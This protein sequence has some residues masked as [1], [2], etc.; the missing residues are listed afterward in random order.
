VVLKDIREEGNDNN[1]IIVL[2]TPSLTSDQNATIKRVNFSSLVVNDIKAF[3]SPIERRFDVSARRPSS[4]P[5]LELTIQLLDKRL[6]NLQTISSAPLTITGKATVDIEKKFVGLIPQSWM[7]EIDIHAQPMLEIPRPELRAKL[8]HLIGSITVTKIPPPPTEPPKP[9]PNAWAVEARRAFSSRL[10][11]ARA[12]Y[13]LENTKGG[14]SAYGEMFR[15]GL[16]ISHG[17]VVLPTEIF[18]PWRYNPDIQAQL[19][20]K[21][22]RVDQNSVEIRVWIGSTDSDLVKLDPRAAFQ[23]RPQRVLATNPSSGPNVDKSIE[24]GTLT[25]CDFTVP[26]V[27]LPTVNELHQA[28]PLGS[29]VAAVFRLSVL[30]LAPRQSESE[31][32]EAIDKVDFIEVKS[33]NGVFQLEQ[34]VD[35][36][37][38]GSLVLSRAGLLGVL[39]SRTTIAPLK[40]ILALKDHPPQPEPSKPPPP[41]APAVTSVKKPPEEP[42]KAVVPTRVLT[43]KTTP[44]LASI[45]VDG[46]DQKKK[47][48]NQ[49]TLTVGSHDVEVR[50]SGYVSRKRIIELKDDNLTWQPT[51]LLPDPKGPAPPT[52]GNLVIDSEPRDADVSVDGNPISSA[53][54]LQLTLP[55]GPHLIEITKQGFRDTNVKFEL[56]KPTY[57]LPKFVLDKK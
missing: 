23:V 10:V 25:L 7:R 8:D 22:L 44:G 30:G 31:T 28:D 32:R 55:Y 41:E 24:A 50:L 43:I 11:V 54:P 33:S 52:V 9:D 18:E 36:S 42:A 37:E 16:R 49:L 53:K 2:V 40:E 20:A 29:E 14:Q 6:D 35:T 27:D 19:N 5:D 46:M 57:E 56:N 39:I 38:I 34:R 17:E 45:W 48:P 1:K 12:R 21:T 13:V 26:G 15:A 4:S 3:A 51:A 47:T